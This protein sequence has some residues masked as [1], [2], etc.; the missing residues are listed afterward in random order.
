MLSAAVQDI[1][2][3]Y[4]L[5]IIR[6]VHRSKTRCSIGGDAA[7]TFDRFRAVLDYW[8]ITFNWTE[9]VWTEVAKDLNTNCLVEIGTELPGVY[10]P[11]L[12]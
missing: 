5:V 3:A 4:Q 2:L 7:F 9:M 1:E 8:P 11:R 6:R 12:N 10:V